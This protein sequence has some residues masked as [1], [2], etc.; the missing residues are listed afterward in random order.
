MENLNGLHL[1]PVT[2]CIYLVPFISVDNL[3]AGPGISPSASNSHYKVCLHGRAV[4]DG[5]THAPLVATNALP[6]SQCAGGANRSGNQAGQ[7]LLNTLYLINQNIAN[8]KNR[9][10][11]N[12]RTTGHFP[13]YHLRQQ[14][15]NLK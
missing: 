2:R 5:T 14:A 8:D 7:T 13:A 6:A 3:V 11:K 4:T 1:T 15:T 9:T 10:V 12:V